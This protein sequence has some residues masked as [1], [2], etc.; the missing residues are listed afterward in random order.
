VRLFSSNAE[1]AL[2]RFAC[3][4]LLWGGG[5]DRLDLN[6]QD[7]NEAAIVKARRLWIRGGWHP[8]S[9]EQLT[10]EFLS[11]LGISF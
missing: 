9:D 2:A 3:V 11:K 6:D 10:I 8:P 4:C 5:G 1:K 7:H